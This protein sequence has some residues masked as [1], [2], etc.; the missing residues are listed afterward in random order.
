MQMVRV[1]QLYRSRKYLVRILLSILLLIVLFLV[2]SSVTQYYN[3]ER[4]V[5]EIQDETNRKVLSQ[6]NYNI[7][8]MNELVKNLTMSVYF[9]SDTISLMNSS[10][11]DIF[12]L[13]PKVSRLTQTKASS[14]F[15]ESIFVYNGFNRCYYSSEAK[16]KLSCQ[17]DGLDNVL[18]RYLSNHDQIAR[19]R[20]VPMYDD[21]SDRLY[22]R[23]R[24]FSVFMYDTKDDR[25]NR[26]SILVINIKPEWLFNHIRNINQLTE[27]DNSSILI[28]DDNGDIFNAQE[29]PDA[30]R[31]VWGQA[32]QAHIAKTGRAADYFNEGSGRNKKSIS[33]MTSEQNGWV[34]VN[35]QSYDYIFGKMNQM[36]T[37]TIVLIGIFLVLSIIVSVVISLG[38]Y[39]PVQHILRQMEKTVPAGAPPQGLQDEFSLIASGYNEAIEHIG[40]LQQEQDA[41]K[42]IMKTYY[43]RKLVVDS[44]TVSEE[45]FP[46]LTERYRIG[47]T[48]TAPMLLCVLKLDNY[49]QFQTFTPAARKLFK[50]AM[51]NI[52]SEI[53]STRFRNEIVDMRSDHFVLLVNIGHTPR[54]PVQEMSELLKEAQE[55]FTGYYRLSF[56]AAIGEPVPDYGTLDRQYWATLECSMY[57]LV[58]GQSAIIVPAMIERNTGNGDSDFPAD[59]EKHLL[60]G[61]R[62][63]NTAQLEEQLDELFRHLAGL[64]HRNMTYLILH[65]IVVVHKAIR[66]INSHNIHQITIDLMPFYKQVI[67]HETLAE[68][69]A[70]FLRL[71]ADI[72]DKRKDANEKSIN[73]ILVDTIKEIIESNY[74]DLNL[75]L[76]SIAS[77]MQLSPTH[78]S[79]IF[80]QHED[81]SIA[82]YM[83]DLRLHRAKLMLEDNKYTIN[84]ILQR[85]GFGNKSYFFKLFKMKY[86][87]TPKEYRIKQVIHET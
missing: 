33:Y 23:V 21:A 54:P 19:L 10:T 44:S 12:E 66:E 17:E 7:E 27:Q 61:L 43:L 36:R 59:I 32:V 48:V 30:G 73:P 62:A 25:Y 11:I 29:Q 41:G 46:Q 28:M 45:E 70:T 56:T 57:R 42:D 69:R 76:Q 34:I 87:T 77:T 16:G 39:K 81:V 78:I 85:V 49:A 37:F 13:F 9:D 51:L 14:S 86:G 65:A 52:T 18:D 63:N 58:Y 82:T 31:E 1:M 79:K 64:H 6:V 35:V 84:E 3:S 24:F 83:T 8:Y 71:F 26:Q 72:G 68:I 67:E 40:W 38:L 22:N 4:T 50:F 47:I 80:R 74:H 5:L 60:E 75:S 53:V 2:I 15:V 55:R 20:L